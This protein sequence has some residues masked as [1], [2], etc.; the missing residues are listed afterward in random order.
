MRR[1]TGLGFLATIVV[2]AMAG[3]CSWWADDGP[4]EPG[5][6]AVNGDGELQRLN[7][8]AEWERETW[9]DRQNFPPDTHFVVRNPA[10][11]DDS[12]AAAGKP[13]VTLRKVGWVRSEIRSGKEIG[14]PRGRRWVTAAIPELQVPVRLVHDRDDVLMVAPQRGA[15]APGLYSLQLESGGRQIQARFGVG[16][17]G[18][19][20]TRYAGA[21][22]MDRYVENAATWYTPCARQRLATPTDGLQIRLVQPDRRADEG[23]I[24]LVVKGTIAN[25]S[26]Q[27]RAIPMLQGQLKDDKG[28]V[29]RRWEFASPAPKLDPGGY[30]PFA[31][32]AKDVPPTATDLTVRFQPFSR[33]A[34]Q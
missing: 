15:L 18:V 11:D 23:K 10:P 32:V 33:A 19:D 30:V 1:G 24:S 9:P 25:T 26:R 29:V 21:H 13:K 3:G 7:G 28:R 14:P 34:L 27:A 22:C 8:S 6:Y 5:L 17:S 2:A 4:E 16:W 12:A 20:E 31:T